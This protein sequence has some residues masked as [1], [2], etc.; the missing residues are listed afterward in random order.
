VAAVTFEIVGAILDQET[1]AVGASIREVARLRKAYGKGAWRKRKGLARIR[2]A[3]GTIRTAEIHWYEAHGL[4]RREYK[5][6]RIL[7]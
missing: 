7:P 6:K 1:I 4:G 5:I 3:N 2:L